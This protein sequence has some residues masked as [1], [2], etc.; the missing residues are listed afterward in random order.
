MK[1]ISFSFATIMVIFLI[2]S[3]ASAIIPTKEQIS[4]YEKKM[5]AH[6]KDLIEI[7]KNLNRDDAE[8]TINLINIANEYSIKLEYIQDIILIS[9][10][11]SNKTDKAQIEPIVIKIIKLFMSGI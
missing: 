5:M 3:V 1:K 8:I 4:Q 10:L 11:I 2:P 6:R 9:S 7:C